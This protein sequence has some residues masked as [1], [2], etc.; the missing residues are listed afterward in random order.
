MK[1][2]C[3]YTVSKVHSWADGSH[4]QIGDKKYENIK[5]KMILSEGLNTH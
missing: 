1:I 5:N 3:T 4:L 2:K